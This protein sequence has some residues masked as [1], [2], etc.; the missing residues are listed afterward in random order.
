[1]LLGK[2]GLLKAYDLYAWKNADILRR[3]SYVMCVLG[4]NRIKLANTK[5]NV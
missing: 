4:T 1:M 2:E 5:R 3:L